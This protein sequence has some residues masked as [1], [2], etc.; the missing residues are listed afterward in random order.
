MSWKI[1]SVGVPLWLFFWCAVAAVCLFSRGDLGWGTANAAAAITMAVMAVYAWRRPSAFSA[2][3]RKS[4]IA[5][6][7][8]KS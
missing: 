3:N 2:T 7:R 8:S 1:V 4:Q 6:R 5:N